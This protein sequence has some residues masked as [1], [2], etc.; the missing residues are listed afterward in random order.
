MTL[1]RLTCDGELLAWIDGTSGK[2]RLT[3][4]LAVKRIG[5]T[6]IVVSGLSNSAV[7]NKLT[8]DGKRG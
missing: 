2:Q 5:D 8:W 1:D 4:R 3:E 6:A 7:D